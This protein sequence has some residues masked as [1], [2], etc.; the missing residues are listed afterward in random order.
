MEL[1][2]RLFAASTA[3]SS[4]FAR[5]DSLSENSRDATTHAAQ[6]GR[7]GV[8]SRN[9]L[10][11]AVPVGCQNGSSVGSL[12]GTPS[13]A[14][15]FFSRTRQREGIRLP[16]FNKKA[17]ILGRSSGF[18]LDG[19]GLPNSPHSAAN[20]WLS[21]EPASTPFTAARPRWN[22]SQGSLTRH[23][24]TLPFSA[25]RGFT[26]ITRQS[27]KNIMRL[28][29]SDSPRQV[30]SPDHPNESTTLCLSLFFTDT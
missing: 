11:G 10:M 28:P 8:S 17:E 14:A 4:R 1:T 13:A 29:A 16:T 24:T 6:A 27:T 5:D 21:Q 30:Y 18:G 19:S 12:P 23:L 9:S 15:G 20:Q 7:A 25:L 2:N 22:Q 3:C 26:R